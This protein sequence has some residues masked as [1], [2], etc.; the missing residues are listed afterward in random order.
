VWLFWGDA[1]S[2]PR[3]AY[4]APGRR[5]VHLLDRSLNL[6]EEKHSHGLRRLAAI[7]AARGSHEAACAAITR[8]TGVTIGKRQ[9]EAL[10]RRAA[11]HVKEF[12][13]WRVTSP[14]PDDHAAFRCWLSCSR[15][16]PVGWR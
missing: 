4:R 14:A 6:P 3:I 13:L 5:N 15:S 11:A 16:Q 8:A 10:A 1:V 12:Y 7:E 2:V 9:M